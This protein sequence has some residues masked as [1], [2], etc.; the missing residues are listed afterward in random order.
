LGLGGSIGNRG[1]I[2][3]HSWSDKTGFA[4][5]APPFPYNIGKEVPF[6]IGFV[7]VS[8]TIANLNLDK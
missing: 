7:R 2:N 8:K 1:F 3:S 6:T 4:I 5:M